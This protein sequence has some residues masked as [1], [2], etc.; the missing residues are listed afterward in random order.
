MKCPRCGEFAATEETRGGTR[1]RRVCRNGHSFHTIE[2]VESTFLPLVKMEQA[3]ATLREK[4][5]LK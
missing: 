1:R 5:W 2:V 3:R 4:G